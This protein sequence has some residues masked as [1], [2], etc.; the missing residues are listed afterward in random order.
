M[1]GVRFP[2]HKV[3]QSMKNFQFVAFM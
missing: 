3:K 2:L 1:L